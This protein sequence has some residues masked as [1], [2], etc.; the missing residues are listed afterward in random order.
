MAHF[1]RVVILLGGSLLALSCGSSM[2]PAESKNSTFQIGRLHILLPPIWKWL[3]SAP[4]KAEPGDPEC[5]CPKT[6]H[7]LVAN[8]ADQPLLRILAG[9]DTLVLDTLHSIFWPGDCYEPCY[10]PYAT[11]RSSGDI[12]SMV[13]QNIAVRRAVQERNDDHKVVPAVIEKEMGG[14][15]FF[16]MN[17]QYHVFGRSGLYFSGN[18]R[19]PPFNLY[20][21]FIHPET[22]EKLY[23]IWANAR[24][25]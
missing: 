25:E 7:M 5:I 20:G 19:Q 14:I 13:E 8:E 18:S 12:D 17:G 4:Y 10:Y 2:R 15:S 1:L 22:M 6:V 24:W 3:P 11:L 21:R 16:A 9:M 23:E